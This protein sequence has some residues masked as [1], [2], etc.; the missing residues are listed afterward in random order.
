M[1]ISI[2]EEKRNL[3]DAYVFPRLGLGG[4]LGRG[5]RKSIALKLL[6]R[7]CLVLKTEKFSEL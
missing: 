1:Q 2:T 3:H 7:P 6:I 4:G 5:V